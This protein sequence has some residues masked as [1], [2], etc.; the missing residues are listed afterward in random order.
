MK[1]TFV[2]DTDVLLQSPGA[3]Y[4][5]RDDVVVLSDVVLEEL[6]EFKKEKGEFGCQCEEN[7]Q[8]FRET[9]VICLEV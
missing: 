4:S 2:I 6:E 9:Q 5:F 7:S 3:V 1:K 8:N